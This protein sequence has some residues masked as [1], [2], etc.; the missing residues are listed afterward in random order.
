MSFPPETVYGLYHDHYYHHYSVFSG[1][2]ISSL[3]WSLRPSAF[4][5]FLQQQLPFQRMILGV[6]LTDVN[7]ETNFTW[8]DGDRHTLISFANSLS[9]ETL[10][11]GIDNV[12]MS[13]LMHQ[14]GVDGL[15]THTIY[16]D[17][18]PTRD[19][20][21]PLDG[22]VRAELKRALGILVQWRIDNECD[23]LLGNAGHDDEPLPCVP[24]RLSSFSPFLLPLNFPNTL[25]SFAL[26]S[27]F[28][29]FH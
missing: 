26:G 8:P 24:F 4:M 7:R 27:F 19:G 17:G 16:P 18:L 14:L 11:R 15:E 1:N 23:L 5:M 6:P 28:S 29:P 12:D 21:R 9:P 3:Q 25:T 13:G 10:Y 20:A 2:I 22:K